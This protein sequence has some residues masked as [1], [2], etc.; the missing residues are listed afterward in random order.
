[1]R[2]SEQILTSLV[3]MSARLEAIVRL[4]GQG[5]TVCDVGCDHAH[6]PIRLLQTGCYRRAIGMDVIAGPL[7]KAAANLA[8]YR[9]EDRV[10]LR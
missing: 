5:D 4:V 8:L 10:Q 1:M 9:M 7:G 3:P 6:V 2:E